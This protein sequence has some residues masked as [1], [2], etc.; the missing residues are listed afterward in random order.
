MNNTALNVSTDEINLHCKHES[1]QSV[2]SI[3]EM[4][5]TSVQIVRRRNGTDYV[6]AEIAT[7]FLVGSFF[8]FLSVCLLIAFVYLSVV[9]YVK[10]HQKR[11][12]LT[13]LHTV[14]DEIASI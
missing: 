8:V 1:V 9:F 10:W 13:A 2:V 7:D 12:F 3:Y 5:Q 4:H 6:V 14:Q 11:S